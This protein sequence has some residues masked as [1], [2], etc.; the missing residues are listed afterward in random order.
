[1]FDALAECVVLA[2]RNSVS[3]PPADTLMMLS[4]LYRML[5]VIFGHAGKAR[6]GLQPRLS[7][8]QIGHSL[9]ELGAV[10]PGSCRRRAPCHRS[11]RARIPAP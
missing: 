8:L 7:P 2:A 1:M 4:T 11:R 3:I 10:A 9:V 5:V 6:A